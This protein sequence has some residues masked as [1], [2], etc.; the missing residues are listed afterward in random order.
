MANFT[1]ALEE[2]I[3]SE[4]FYSND[5]VDA[6]GETYY[7]IARKKNPGW[8]GWEIIDKLRREPNFLA[9][10]KD[11]PNLKELLHIFYRQQFW[12]VIRGDMI[13]DYDKAKDIF[14]MAVN[15]GCS[16]SIKIAQRALKLPDTGIM[17]D[18]TLNRLN[19]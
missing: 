13:N 8:R 14:D 10:I 6:G 9:L 16:A 4:G 11:H 7:G 5:P 18:A 2:V 1:R 17:D 19:A 12:N 3:I 15:A